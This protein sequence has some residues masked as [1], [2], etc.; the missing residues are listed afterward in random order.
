LLGQNPSSAFQYCIYS[1]LRSGIK[2]TSDRLLI[3]K[4]P[5]VLPIFRLL[6]R[7]EPQAF[8]PQIND[9]YGEAAPEDLI[10][11][12]WRLMSDK[13]TVEH[14]IS[15]GRIW[16]PETAPARGVEQSVLIIHGELGTRVP[17][18]VAL[19]LTRLTPN[20]TLKLLP[21]S[22]YWPFASHTQI[23]ESEIKKLLQPQLLQAASLA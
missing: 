9:A 14:W 10:Q 5:L 21:N 7:F 12:Y 4:T 23:V 6:H 17:A 1:C 20:P 3:G 19:E 22:W 11:D 8:R 2:R 16:Q 18:Q 13:R 15:D